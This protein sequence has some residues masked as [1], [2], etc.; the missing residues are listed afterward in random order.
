MHAFVLAR[1]DTRE[2][3]QIISLF[4]DERGKIDALAKSVKK[5]ISKNSP[6]LEPFGLVNVELASGQEMPVLKTA[7]TVESFSKLMQSFEL[8]AAGKIILNLVREL[9][10]NHQPEPDLWKFLLEFFRQLN[11][12]LLVGGGAADI[13]VLALLG[14]L[15]F[16]PTVR[17]CAVCGNKITLQNLGDFSV[18]AGGVRCQKCAAQ[19]RSE[20]VKISTGVW[21]LF[22]G[23]NEYS[24]ASVN[25]KSQFHFLVHHFLIFHSGRKIA[26]W[27]I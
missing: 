24:T 13:G 7:Q 15:G 19:G 18:S 27:K 6:A 22:L 14:V 20:G 11:S 8:L 17:T 4:T 2:S 23:T 21:L 5:I 10:P 26:D 25:D 3:D 12:G 9:A 16:A 1:R